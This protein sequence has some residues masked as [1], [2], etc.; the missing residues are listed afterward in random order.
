MRVEIVRGGITEQPDLEAVVNSANPYLI[1]GSGVAGA[2]HR[3]AGP[4][5]EA[6]CKPMAP[7]FPGKAVI[8]PGFRL[9]NTWVIHAV[10]GHYL[11]TPEPERVLRDAVSATLVI[12]GERGIRSLGLPAIGTGVYAF[13]PEVAAREMLSVLRAE[14]P[15]CL[16]R[17]RICVFD[18][19]VLRAFDCEIGG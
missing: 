12:V 13:P 15:D 4:E 10:A 11:T 18:A 5:M 1:S 7:L 9:S 2:I 14:A 6:Y 16:E 3:A 17:V 19:R 8:T